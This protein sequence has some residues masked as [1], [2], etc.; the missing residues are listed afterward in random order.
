MAQ[1]PI[2]LV[3]ARHIKKYFPIRPGF[4]AKALAG[5]QEKTV[6]AVDDVNLTIWP[7]ETVGLGGESGCGKTTLGLVMASVHHMRQ[8]QREDERGH[9][10]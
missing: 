1:S 10:C 2:P 9:G 4:L 6:K 7:G 3:E 8:S 5:Q